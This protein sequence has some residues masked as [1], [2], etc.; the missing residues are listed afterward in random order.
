MTSNPVRPCRD[1]RRPGLPRWAW[2]GLGAAAALPLGLMGLT[3]VAAVALPTLLQSREQD[4]QDEAG[5]GL[6][7]LARAVKSYEAIYDR[8]P[9][10]LG[11]LCEPDTG[12]LRI[13]NDARPLTDPWG[14]DYRYEAPGGPRSFGRVWTLGRDDAPGGE[15]GDQDRT[16]LIPGR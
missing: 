8:Y 10:D 14:R 2:I 6:A 11:Q 12:G 15:G 16:V 3:F 13:L 1:L 9:E 7:L 4:L 5:A